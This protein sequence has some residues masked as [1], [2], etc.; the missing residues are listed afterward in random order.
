MWLK[1]FACIYS[2]CIEK[3]FTKMY[4]IRSLA[5][6]IMR[7]G[8][9]HSPTIPTLVDLVLKADIQELGHL[10]ALEYFEGYIVWV[11]FPK[12]SDVV[13]AIRIPYGNSNMGYM[14]MPLYCLTRCWKKIHFIWSVYGRYRLTT[15][16]ICGKRLQGSPLFLIVKKITIFESQEYGRTNLLV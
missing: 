15:A 10:Y 6:P 11:F 4:P 9:W 14:P 12:L 2:D 3:Q 13:L 7:W 1:G 16:A 5:S 8:H